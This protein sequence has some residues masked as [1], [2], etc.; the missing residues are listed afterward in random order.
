MLRERATVN[1]AKATTRVAEPLEASHVWSL[2]A[3]CGAFDSVARCDC[4]A[5]KLDRL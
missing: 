3:V 4:M 5:D 1:I 2:L